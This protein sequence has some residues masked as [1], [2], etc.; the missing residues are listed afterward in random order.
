[1]VRNVG[2]QEADALAFSSGTSPGCTDVD[3]SP[4]VSLT[5]KT[6]AVVVVGRLRGAGGAL[7]WDGEQAVQCAGDGAQAC[8]PETYI[9]LLTN[10]TPTNSIRKRL[11]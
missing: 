6:G 4:S 8:T 5:C 2:L 11:K 9:I 7:T 1:M 10:V 3:G